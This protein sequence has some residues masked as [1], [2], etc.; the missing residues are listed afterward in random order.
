MLITHGPLSR[1]VVKTFSDVRR[2]GLI[3]GLCV[4]SALTCNRPTSAI[5]CM[6]ILCLNGSRHMQMDILITIIGLTDI[7]CLAI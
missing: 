2:V 7:G 1:K 3:F 5:Y 4:S 6:Y